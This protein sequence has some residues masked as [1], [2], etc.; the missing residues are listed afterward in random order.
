MSPQMVLVLC[1]DVVGE[2]V[3]GPGIR[4]REIAR[5][6]AQH[7]RVI[8]AVPNQSDLQ[9]EAFEVWP[10]GRQ[11]WDSLLPAARQAQVILS[12]GDSLAEFPA[13]E[14]LGVPLIVDGYDP[15]MLE[16]L[17][18]WANAP[19]DVQAVHYRSR[20]DILRRQ[21]RAGDFFLCA[22]ERQRDW[23]LGLL[24][25]GGRLNPHTY[26]ADPSLRNLI[27]LVPYG[28]PSEP[29]KAARRVLRGVWPGIEAGDRLLLWGGGLWEWFDP[30][31]AVRA[32]YRLVQEG[33]GDLR[34]VFPGTRHPNP[35]MP[36]MPMR[37]ATVALTQELG[38]HGSHAFFGDW[39]PHDDWPAVLLEADVGLSLHPDTAEARLAF[40]TRL[41]DY[42]WAGLPMT[43]TAGDTTSDI[44]SE[45]G[46]GE[47]VPPRDVTAV[48]AAVDRLLKTPD[49]RAAYQDAFGRLRSE[50][51][52]E[53]ACEPL[54]R[55]CQNPTFAADRA[56]GSLP[57]AIVDRQAVANQDAEI[58]RLRHLVEGY[59]QG[60]FMHLMR[61]WHRWRERL[62]QR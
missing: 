59:E 14:T 36:D 26:T 19:M 3:A 10:Y 20:L 46:L 42:I 17:A 8:L 2:R 43:V 39:V 4:Y 12:P 38:L 11:I 24:E 29:P 53:R 54:V 34:L 57:A 48:A 49:L 5:V 30:L 23:W 7:F 31:T 37:T 41:V 40:R 60:R 47:V 56:A 21:C 51:T 22:N 27:D 6:L 28:V 32:V 44:V 25:R 9:D 52:W 58:K 18:L 16:T 35:S 45:H 15:H 55:F 50:L 33:M 62:G 61:R 13:L 1:H